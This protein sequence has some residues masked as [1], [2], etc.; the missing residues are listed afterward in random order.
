[1]F[2]NSILQ[3]STFFWQK[4][5]IILIPSALAKINSKRPVIGTRITPPHAA[6]CWFLPAVEFIFKMNACTRCDRLWSYFTPV[7]AGCNKGPGTEIASLPRGGEAIF[8]G[9]PCLSLVLLA[10]RCHQARVV[11]VDWMSNFAPNGLRGRVGKWKMGLPVFFT[12]IEPQIA[13]CNIKRPHWRF[14]A[15]SNN[16]RC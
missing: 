4:S 12:R 6:F 13:H 7:C 10:D 2:L 5:T 16:K 1:M 15:H 3:N 11:R 9:R 8:L 14:V